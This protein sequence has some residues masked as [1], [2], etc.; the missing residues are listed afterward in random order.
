MEAR[1][2]HT[3]AGAL[4]RDG[5]VHVGLECQTMG[6]GKSTLLEISVGFET[7]NLKICEDNLFARG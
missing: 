2:Q 5:T 1:R 7:R 6:R 3:E 4:E